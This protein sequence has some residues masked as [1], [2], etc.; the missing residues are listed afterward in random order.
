MVSIIII[1]SHSSGYIL[2][3]FK[4]GPEALQKDWD[5][6]QKNLLVE[7]LILS[8]HSIKKHNKINPIKVISTRLRTSR[9]LLSCKL[10]PVP[11]LTFT[12]LSSPTN[13]L[14]RSLLFQPLWAKP[15]LFF[16]LCLQELLSKIHSLPLFVPLLSFFS[17]Y[18]IWCIRPIKIQGFWSDS[19]SK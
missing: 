11:H 9:Y 17:A 1:G 3:S 8:H 15:L 12:H 6:V 13:R 7:W 10:A 5:F 4:Y 18:H 14:L 2:N 19:I 16:L